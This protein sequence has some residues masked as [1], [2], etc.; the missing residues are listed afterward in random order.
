MKRYLT[1]LEIFSVLII[2]SVISFS[3][4]L[5]KSSFG[6]PGVYAGKGIWGDYNNDGYPD[7]L[8]IGQMKEASGA[9]TNIAYLYKNNNGSL[10]KVQELEGVYFGDAAWGDYDNDGDLDLII[11]G[12]NNDGD[13]TAILYK[14]QPTGTLTKDTQQTNLIGV[15]YSSCEWG[16][17]NKDGYLDLVVCGMDRFGYANTT[18]YYSKR[19]GLTNL[20]IPDEKQTLLNINKGDLAW[21]DYDRDGN[22]DLVVSGFNTDGRRSAKVYKNDPVGVLKEDNNLSDFAD[23]IKGSG[24]NLSVGD[25]D[26]DGDFDVMFTGWKDGWIPETALYRNEPLGRFGDNILTTVQD[27]IGPTLFADFDNDGDF[28]IIAAGRDNFSNIYCFLL[29]NNGNN[30]FTEDGNQTELEPL[31]EG[32][33]SVADI[34]DDGDLDLFSCGINSSGERKSYIYINQESDPSYTPEPPS[35]LNKPVVTNDDVLFSWDKVDDTNTPDEALTYILQVGTSSGKNDVFSGTIPPGY[36]NALSEL[37]LNL[38]KK[39]NQGTYYWSVRTVDAQFNVSSKSVEKIFTVQ[40]F[41]NS[42]QNL[43]G[44]QQAVMDFA[45][46]NNDGYVDLVIAGQDINGNNRA[47]LYDNNEGILEENRDIILTKFRYGDFA[48]GDIDNDGD[49]D[50]IYAGNYIRSDKV[51]GVYINEPLGVLTEDMSYSDVLEQVDFASLDLG[52][53]DDDGDL[54]LA[55]MG[56]NL[57]NVPVTK[58]YKNDGEGNFSEDLSHN[59]IGYANGKLE[60]IDVD[61]DGDLDLMICGQNSEGDN[62]ARLYLNDNYILTEDQNNHFPEFIASTFDWAD[63]DSDGDYDMIFTGQVGLTS[64]TDI[65]Y[66]ENNGYGL[67][68]EVP[69]VTSIIDGVKG[70]SVQFA[71]YDNDGDLDLAISGNDET[72]PVLKIYENDNGLTIDNYTVMKDKGIDFS[73]LKFVDINKDGDLDLFTV[74]RAKTGLVSTAQVFD[75]IEGQ[76]NEN[77]KPLPPTVLESTVN[78]DTVHLN[79]GKGSDPSGYGTSEN[80][81]KYILR[82]GSSS[83]GNDIYSGV[84]GKNYGRD[85]FSRIKKIYNL[86][87]GVYYWS[88]RSVDNGFSSSNWSVEQTFTIDVIKP[89]IGTISVNPSSLGIGK[90]TVLIN[91]DENFQLDL[92]QSPTVSFKIG[93]SSSYNVEQVSYD[94]KTWIGE[95]LV[96]SSYPS[97]TAV[98]S[99]SGAVDMSH[100]VMN[101]VENAATFLIDT[102]LPHVE[103]TNPEPDQSGV[104]NSIILNAYFNEKLDPTSVNQNSFKLL[105]GNEEVSGTVFYDSDEKR[106]SFTPENKLDGSKEYQAVVLGNVK[107]IVGNTMGI[108]YSW[109]FTTAEVV[110]SGKGGEVATESGNLKLYFSPNALEA[111]QEVSINPLEEAELVIPQD[112]KSIDLFFRLGPTDK[113]ISLNKDAVLK[114]N[115]SSKIGVISFEEERLA[116]YRRDDNDFSSWIRVGGSVNTMERTVSVPIKKLGVFGVFEETAGITGEASITEVQFSPRVFSPNGTTHLPAKTSINFNLGKPMTITIEIFNSTGRLV[117]RLVDNR[118]MNPGYNSVFWDGMDGENRLCTSGIYIVKIHGEGKEQIK[119]VAILNK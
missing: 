67:M 115:Y 92:T 10:Q 72:E 42:N 119:T 93:D 18:V 82:V 35:V 60:W 110:A 114:I 108:D 81:L 79:W 99:V 40:R 111:D 91:F 49:L 85:G 31:R 41:V 21:I 51:T 64:A 58:I 102:E 69:T 34:D 80:A 73:D 83:G 2:F 94:G 87:S 56:S 118:T 113:I 54:D 107:D 11:T 15:K 23:N 90:G 65:V 86:L 75:N 33:L 78:K 116:V 100:N 71:D 39:L 104:S 59:L 96:K 70:G 29:E 76:L 101:T 1:K 26:S 62:K 50:L 37:F 24:V 36:G 53:F 55:L 25:I 7:L 28:D 8:I 22:L 88:V 3:G 52:D 6:L 61:N 57:S 45:D 103:L 16:D 66:Y 105:L 14:N 98:I 48:W 47:I 17:Y 32:A 20:L 112:K 74:G 13:G 117:R 4:N 9:N 38:E 109:F 27:V 68:S 84:I 63:F 89:S 95:I 106:I 43:V 77:F 30:I 46:Y 5:K 44:F 97:G 12:V 19:E